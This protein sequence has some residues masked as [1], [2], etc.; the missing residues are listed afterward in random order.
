MAPG[1]C[2][3]AQCRFPFTHVTSGHQCGR[4]MGFGHGQ[5]ECRSR[6]LRTALS[7]HLDD[8]MPDGVRCTVAGCVTPELHST[9]AHVCDACAQRGSWCACVSGGVGDGSTSNDTSDVNAGGTC[10]SATAPP[11]RRVACPLCRCVNDVRVDVSFFTDAACVVCL[12]R[13]PLV[14]FP[15]CRHASTCAACVARL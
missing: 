14:P 4:C 2:R 10:S 7:V 9:L 15:K 8:R 5:V 1:L 13:A 6:T 3:A 11:T 12:E